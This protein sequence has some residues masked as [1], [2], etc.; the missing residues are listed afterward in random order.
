[1]AKL[2][3]I[4]DN[5]NDLELLGMYFQFT[6]PIVQLFQFFQTLY[7]FEI[8]TVL[9]LRISSSSSHFIMGV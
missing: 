4:M 9:V 7:G 5:V 6:C 8:I 2:L 1:M 3:A